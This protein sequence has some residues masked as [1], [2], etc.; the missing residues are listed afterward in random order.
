M[1]IIK[2]YD[3]RI[4]NIYCTISLVP[5]ALIQIYFFIIYLARLFIE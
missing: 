3:L 4:K 5:V 2:I 1:H